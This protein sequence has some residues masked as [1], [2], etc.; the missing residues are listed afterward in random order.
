MKW[1]NIIDRI[2]IMF[3]SI[4]YVILKWDNINEIV[5]YIKSKKQNVWLTLIY[6]MK[7]EIVEYNKSKK[8]NVSFILIYNMKI[9]KKKMK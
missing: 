9:K 7:N 6:N 4:W 5:E 2:E 3:D 8:Q 1:L